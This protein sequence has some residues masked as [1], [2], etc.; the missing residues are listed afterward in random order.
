MDGCSAWQV[1]CT[2][3]FQVEE[4]AVIALQVAVAD[5]AGRSVDDRLDI[6][7]DGSPLPGGVRELPSAHGGRIHHLEPGL[8]LREVSYQARAQGGTAGHDDSGD[9]AAL[10][11]L[12]ALRPS[13]YCPSDALLGFAV[14]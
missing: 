10:E 2:L 4:P 11:R 5:A 1:G 3:T 12:F 8:G 6:T 7:L 13:R 9:A 14:G